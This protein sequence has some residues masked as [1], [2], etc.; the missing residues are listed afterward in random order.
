[1]T[2]SSKKNAN[3]ENDLRATK[4]ESHLMKIKNIKSDSELSSSYEGKPGF[5]NREDVCKSDTTDGIKSDSEVNKSDGESGRGSSVSASPYD[6]LKS[7]ESDQYSNIAM[8][9][10]GDIRRGKVSLGKL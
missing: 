7:D 5:E 8:S 10:C 4:S 3:N 2:S 1:M 9:L 6:E